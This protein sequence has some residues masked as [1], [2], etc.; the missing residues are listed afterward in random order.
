MG[1]RIEDGT[2]SMSDASLKVTQ[3]SM[4]DGTSVM[5]PAGGTVVFVGPNNAGKSLALREVVI[6]FTNPSASQPRKVVIDTQFEKSG[7]IQSWLQENCESRIVNGNQA[8]S[9]VFAGE[10]AAGN[11]M[12]W[13]N[14]GPPFQSL[15]PFLELYAGPENRLQSVGSVGAINFRSEVPSHPF[16]RLYLDEG[17][18]AELSA[19][20]H[21]A[22]GVGLVLNRKAGSQLH[23]HVGDKPEGLDQSPKTRAYLDS[24]NELPLLS[25]QG[26]GMKS[27]M[28]I[29]LNLTGANYFTILIDEPEAFL[30]PPQAQLLGQMLAGKRRGNAQVFLATHSSDV[31]RGVLD[32]KN[33]DVTIV[34][35]VR[36]SS[37]N[38]TTQL[39]PVEVRKLW[40]DPVL[41]YS[42]V[43]DGLFNRAVILCEGDTDCKFYAACLDVVSKDEEQKPEILFTHCGGKQRMPVVIRA[44]RSVDVP[45][46]AIADFDV[47]RE[48]PTLKTIIDALGGDW[49]LVEKDWGIVKSAIDSDVAQLKRLT[50]KQEAL[51]V[52]DK[53]SSPNLSKAEISQLQSMVKPVT[54]W[55][56]V[57]QSG[58]AAVPKGEAAAA[59][60]RLL[61]VLASLGLNVV[62]EGEVEG[63]VRTVGGHGPAWVN[64][65]YEK[66]LHTLATEA[67]KFVAKVVDSAL[68]S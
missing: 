54:G 45:V 10:Q 61:K 38:R 27:F 20:C 48:K 12:S 15:A 60:D 9:R 41:R 29:L 5:V 2:K 28:G 26:D 51:H 19:M 42:N 65:V 4:S 68:Q 7:D 47:L 13:W 37:V 34:R 36:Q 31:V 66:H 14:S 63:W 49:A 59:C 11:L 44:L 23:L 3:L 39:D 53:A 22:F 57:K 35:L 32:S 62:E 40:Q 21:K 55:D 64:E 33:P 18:E 46:R 25:E 6:A 17:L 8:Y 56:K 30:H 52:L 1:N 16:H 24:I 50:V 67:Q 43:L 58:T